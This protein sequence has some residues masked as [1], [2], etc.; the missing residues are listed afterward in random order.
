MRTQ[1]HHVFAAAAVVVLAVGA[2]LQQLADLAA[3]DQLPQPGRARH[4]RAVK[5]SYTDAQAGS[6][7]GSYHPV[8][9]LE[10][11]GEGLLAIDVAAGIDAGEYH[12]QPLV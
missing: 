9:I 8:A 4:V 10:A 7:G 6:F 12:L 1:V 5:V 2:K 11:D 3:V